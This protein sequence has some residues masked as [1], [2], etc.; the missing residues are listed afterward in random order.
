VILVVLFLVILLSIFFL[1]KYSNKSTTSETEKYSRIIKTIKKYDKNDEKN[2]RIN[3]VFTTSKN[4][5]IIHEY[6]D[7]DEENIS[8]KA[9]KDFL[10]NAITKPTTKSPGNKKLI[11][12]ILNGT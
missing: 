9:K 4:Y 3:N 7:Y 6:D 2:T 10:M 12:K 1:G 8:T 11:L 5:Y